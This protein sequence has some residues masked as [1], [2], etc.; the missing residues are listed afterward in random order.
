MPMNKFSQLMLA[1]AASAFTSGC[2]FNSAGYFTHQAGYDATSLVQSVKTGESV[3]TDGAHYYI[4]LER[5]RFEVPREVMYSAF[6]DEKQ[7]KPVLT[8]TGE[9]ELF[10]IPADFAMFLTGKETG[11]DKPAFMNRVANADEVKSTAT[12]RMPI[13]AKPANYVELYKYKS[14]N[15]GWW[16]T[17]AVF[18]WICVDMPIT[19]VQNSLVLVYGGVMLAVG[20]ASVANEYKKAT[21]PTIDYSSGSSSSSEPPPRTGLTPEQMASHAMHGQCS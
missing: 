5:F 17:A 13:V 21:T 20:A 10:E 11:P 3:L 14:P 1:T 6:D 12:T 2:Y 18:D 16:Y 15:A 8:P 7:E 19:C 9:Y 4:E